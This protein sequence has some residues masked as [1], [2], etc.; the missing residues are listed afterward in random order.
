MC[1]STSCSQWEH[2]VDGHFL[3]LQFCDANGITE[4]KRLDSLY[5]PEL[6]QLWYRSHANCQAVK[7]K[8]NLDVKR[9]VRWKDKLFMTLKHNRTHTPTAHREHACEQPKQSYLNRL[10]RH[11]SDPGMRRHQRCC[12]VDAVV[13]W[14]NG[15]WAH[16][17]PCHDHTMC[18][19]MHKKKKLHLRGG[20]S[21][22][23][24]S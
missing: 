11:L 23:I 16:V 5:L 2:E 17:L 7:R 3:T 6:K 8:N 18:T 19:C 9:W 13:E 22:V 4:C 24:K 14:Y 1:A 20:I 21:K 15:K 10:R 12:K